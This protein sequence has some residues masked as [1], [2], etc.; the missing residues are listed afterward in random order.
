VFEPGYLTV[1]E[2]RAV[3][4]H[5]AVTGTLE[6]FRAW[7]FLGGNAASLRHE[8]QLRVAGSDEH[9]DALCRAF[10]P[11]ETWPEELLEKSRRQ[12]RAG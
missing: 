12:S 2:R 5:I 8:R 6:A 7:L 10:A 4:P 3:R 1:S 11:R 9:W